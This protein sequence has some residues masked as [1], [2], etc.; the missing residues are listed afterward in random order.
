MDFDQLI[1]CL[2]LTV[3]YT[4]YYY[5]GRFAV[6]PLKSYFTGLTAHMRDHDRKL[7]NFVSQS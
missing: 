4:N 7:V 1:A 3:L 2:D 5:L 6:T